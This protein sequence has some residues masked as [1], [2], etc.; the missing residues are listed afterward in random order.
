MEAFDD[1]FIISFPKAGRT[2]V[3]V[4][5][6][7]LLEMNGGDPKRL[8]LIKH[9]HDGMG[10]L[11]HQP[12]RDRWKNN[13]IILLIR[14]PR[15][16]IVSFYF[17]V[18]LRE[19]RI[20]HYHGSM[21]QFI[22]DPK[23]GISNIIKFYNGWQKDKHVPK[24]LIVVRYE[25]MKDNPVKEL[26]RM[27]EM[28]GVDSVIDDLHEI[29]EYSSFENMK[30]MDL[31]KIPHLLINNGTLGTVGATPEGLKVRRGKVGGFVDY[32]SYEEIDYVN[33]AM[34]KLH[35]SFGYKIL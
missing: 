14:D 15:D 8:E 4:M 29:V 26:Q 13:R 5:L 6:A 1:V 7:K 12:S 18:T 2:W 28:L 23:Y 3:R 20:W 34:I 30:Q 24:D 11:I 16:I 31:K 35:P 22:K 10:D 17:H 9:D 25:D 33:N 21:S 27:C 19:E 32:L